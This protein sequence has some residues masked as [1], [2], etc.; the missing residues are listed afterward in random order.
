LKEISGINLKSKE[1]MDE[2]LN[3]K[4]LSNVINETLRLYTPA[5]NTLHRVALKDMW[6]DDLFIK[7]GQLVQVTLYSLQ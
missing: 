1:D 7:K 4:Y 5:P 6:I 3:N 2:L